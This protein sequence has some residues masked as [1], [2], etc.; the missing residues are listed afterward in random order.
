[1]MSRSRVTLICALLFC[2]IEGCG[3]GGPAAPPPDKRETGKDI[4]KEERADKKGSAP[5]P[6]ITAK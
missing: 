5:V 1:M 6:G 3:E 2:V 4:S